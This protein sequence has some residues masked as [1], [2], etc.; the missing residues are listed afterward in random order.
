MI[1]LIQ[2]PYLVCMCELVVWSD[3][4]IETLDHLLNLLFGLGDLVQHRTIVV[5]VSESTCQVIPSIHYQQCGPILVVSEVSLRLDI[6]RLSADS[7]CIHA[8]KPFT[9]CLSQAFAD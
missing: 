3:V 1:S 8:F 4:R 9:D 7:V 2:L 6:T 5:T